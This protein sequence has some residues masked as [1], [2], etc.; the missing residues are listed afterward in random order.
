MMNE[1][2]INEQ[3]AHIHTLLENKRLKEALMQLESLLWQC[4]DWD[5]KAQLEQLQTTYNYMLDY[6]RQGA[7]DPERWNVYRKLMADTWSIAD[8]SRLLML[9]NVSPKYFHEVRRTS[10]LAGLPTYDL[11]KILYALESAN[12]DLAISTLL[13]EDKTEEG[14]KRHEEL[15]KYLFAQGWTNSAW[16]TKEE[17]DAH[18]LLASEQLLPEDLCL[19]VS[20]ILLSLIE[21][22][23]LRKMMW[24]LKACQHP[25]TNVSQRAFVNTVI[26]CHVYRNRLALYPELQ[27]RMYIMAE[28]THFSESISRIYQQLLL[29]QE[30]EKIDRKMREEIIPEMIKNAPTMQNPRFGLE[31]NEEENNDKNPDWEELFGQSELGEKLREISELQ[32]EGADV[33]MSTFSSLKNYPFFREIQNWLYPFTPFQRDV[34]KTKKGNENNPSSLL[35]LILQSGLFSNSD[36]YSFFFTVQHLSKDQQKIMLNQLNEQE[37]AQLEERSNTDSLKKINE[38]PKTIT[39]QYLHDLYRFFKLNVR[40]QEFRDIFKERLD[41]H[42]ISIFKDI[43]YNKETLL[44]IAEFYLKKER[45]DE[46]IETYEDINMIENTVQ[47]NVAFWQKWGFALQ[48]KKK[49]TKAIEAYLKV[50]MLKPDNIWNNRHLAIC[51]R[52]NRNYQAALTYYKKVEEVTPEDANIIFY[53]GSCL[54]ESEQYEEAL[55]YFFKLDFTENDSLRAWRGIGWCSF[56]CMKYEQAIKYYEKIIERKPLAIDYMN[57]GHAAWVM[58]DIQKAAEFYRKAITA[59]ESKEQLMEIF[60]KDKD[61]LLKQGIRE[62]DIPLM[63]DLL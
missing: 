58:G 25:N 48:K 20:A 22:F 54:A 42:H 31:E 34:Y 47:N 10:H 19:Y 12:D 9:D 5:L 62:E 60:Y 38:I 11:K 61:P 7:N 43:L 26:V 30:T 40:R 29:C 6:M 55:N 36:K 21:C 18:A 49:Y 51:Y 13:S 46:A 4:S 53:I 24:L 28:N 57:A 32:L 63:L 56:I 17:E 1:K 23:D 44:P 35:D 16:N 3:Y 33:Y 2:T 41:L 27:S 50:D 14:L 37:L 52:L 45:W 39:N 59:S 8:Q 15:L